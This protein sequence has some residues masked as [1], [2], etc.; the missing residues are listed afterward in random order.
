MDFWTKTVFPRIFEDSAVTVVIITTIN[1][2]I[3]NVPYLFFPFNIV[4][5]SMSYEFLR[6][7]NIY[8]ALYDMHIS[9]N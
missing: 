3:F 1:M 8:A 5:A 4:D 7:I 2:I 6:C 9:W